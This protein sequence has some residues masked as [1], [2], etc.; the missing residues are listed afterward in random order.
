MTKELWHNIFKVSVGI[1]A[2]SALLVLI[3]AFTPIWDF[4]IA[5]G[6]LLGAVGASLSFLFLGFVVA[7]AVEKD[8]KNAKMYVQASYTGRLLFMG[9]VIV[10]GIMLPFT[11]GYATAVPFILIRP[12]VMV[13][14]FLVKKKNGKEA[15]A[16]ETSEE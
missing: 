5:T 10:L 11:N 4:K 1:F 9:A 3:T 14:N 12:V 2:L 7:K 8:E 15:P 13:V 16:E 6:A